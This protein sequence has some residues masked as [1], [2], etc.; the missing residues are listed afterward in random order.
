[1]IT[2]EGK[3][4]LIVGARRVGAVLAQRM[5]RE[6]INIAIGYRSSAAEAE[7]LRESL[8]ETGR[9]RLHGAG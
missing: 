6:G 5:A 1:M 4:A 8:A 3:G 2:L 7:S 9:H